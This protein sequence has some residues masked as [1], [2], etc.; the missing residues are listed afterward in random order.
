MFVPVI[1]N[2]YYVFLR[3]L[4]IVPPEPPSPDLIVALKVES[5]CFF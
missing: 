4:T 2:R 5:A 3:C 1:D